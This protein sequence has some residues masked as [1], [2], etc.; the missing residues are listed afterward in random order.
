[1]VKN[2]REKALYAIESLLKDIEQ[3]LAQSDELSEEF[4]AAIERLRQMCI[5]EKTLPGREED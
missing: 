4:R 1:V 2:D 3:V 5:K